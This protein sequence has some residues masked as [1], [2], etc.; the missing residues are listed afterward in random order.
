[1]I[2]REF[3]GVVKAPNFKA[4]SI[5]NVYLDSTQDTDIV[6]SILQK[7]AMMNFFGSK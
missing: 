7:Q 2:A 1:M 3:G 6:S 5:K 4:A